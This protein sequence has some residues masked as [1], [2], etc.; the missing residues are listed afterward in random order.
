MKF[1]SNRRTLN[2]L[3]LFILIIFNGVVFG[4]LVYI[5]SNLINNTKKS[6]VL[7]VSKDVKQEMNGKLQ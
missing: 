5:G 4:F 1:E 3:A 2:Y 6:Q 7:D